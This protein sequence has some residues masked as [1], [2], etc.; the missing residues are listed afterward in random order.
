MSISGNTLNIQCGT[1]L[2]VFQVCTENVIMIDLRPNGI[3]SPDTLVIGN[4]TWAPVQAAI[5]TS[6]I[7]IKITTSKYKIAIDRYPMRFYAYNSAGELLCFEPITQGISQSGIQLTTTGGNFYGVHNHRD[8]GLQTTGGNIFAGSQGEAGAPFIWTTRGWGILADVDSGRIDYSTN[9]INLITSPTSKINMDVY[10]LFGS[11]KEIINAMTDVTGKPPLFPKF[12]L[13]FLNS[14][15]GIDQ[16]S[17]LSYV[18]TYR[19]KEFLSMH[20]SSTLIG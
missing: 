14:Q 18:S 19:A 12:T 20:I 1:D 16:T 3:K 6:S 9:S 17:L 15:W 5:D 2:V 10:L 8:G 7:P 11:P 4:T 13:G